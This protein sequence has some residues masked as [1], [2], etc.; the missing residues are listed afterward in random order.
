MAA[1]VCVGGFGVEVVS[2]G[3]E[4]VVAPVGPQLALGAEQAAAAYDQAQLRGRV[5]AA[6]VFDRLPGVV[7]DGRG[8]C[9]DLGVLG[10]R[11]RVAGAV[12]ADGCDHVIGEEPRVG[13]HRHRRVRRQAP[14]PR[15]GLTSEAHVA[16]LRRPRPHRDAMA[17]RT[18]QLVAVELRTTPPQHRPAPPTPTRPTRPRHR[19]TD[20]RQTH[21]LAQPLEP[22]QRPYPLTLLERTRLKRFEIRITAETNTRTILQRQN[23]H[24]PRISVRSLSDVETA[25]SPR[26]APVQALRP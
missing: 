3:D 11:D 15:Q 12:G 20:H 22:T 21:R 6:G 8:R 17:R 18:H 14:H 24:T 19:P 16:A 10:D 4:A 1:V 26:P 23:R 13:A 2:V 5:A 25:L 9:F 7:V